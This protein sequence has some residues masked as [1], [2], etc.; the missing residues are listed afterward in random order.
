M[1]RDPDNT[2][3]FEGSFEADVLYLRTL[4]NTAYAPRLAVTKPI[5]LQSMRR[6]PSALTKEIVGLTSWYVLSPA[7]EQIRPKSELVQSS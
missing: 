4:P 5:L 1:G 7:F 3:N 6:S 2:R